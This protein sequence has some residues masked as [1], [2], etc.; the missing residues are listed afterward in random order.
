LDLEI[1][2]NGVS[3]KIQPH[4]LLQPARRCVETSDDVTE[5]TF[6]MIRD[7][8]SSFILC[9]PQSSGRSA[10]SNGRF[11][12]HKRSQLFICAHNE[13]LSVTAM[14]ISNPDRSPVRIHR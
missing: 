12:F 9:A 5:E 11:E 2:L 13:T 4:G 3:A 6:T 7:S 8:L 10:R 1:A 14:R